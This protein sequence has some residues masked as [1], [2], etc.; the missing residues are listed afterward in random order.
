VLLFLGFVI[1]GCQTLGQMNFSGLPI[2]GPYAMMKCTVITVCRC[3][4][5][6]KEMKNAIVVKG[7]LHLNLEDPSQKSSG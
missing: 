5:L 1:Y 4:M 7:A 6:S 2:E 3:K